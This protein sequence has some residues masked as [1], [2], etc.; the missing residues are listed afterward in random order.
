M[1]H[2]EPGNNL[3]DGGQFTVE[4]ISPDLGTLNGKA[5]TRIELADDPKPGTDCLSASGDCQEWDD[6]TATGAFSWNWGSCCTDGMVLSGLPASNFRFNM[7]VT[8]FVGL[9]T[10]EFASYPLTGGTSLEYVGIDTVRG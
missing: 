6:A 5:P 9:D 1:V 4:I 8:R 7:K 2:D 3:N 10:F